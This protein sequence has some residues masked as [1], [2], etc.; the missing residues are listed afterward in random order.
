[1]VVWTTVVSNGCGE[2]RSDSVNILNAQSIVFIDKLD[3]R[4]E[5]KAMYSPK[6]LY[7][8]NWRENCH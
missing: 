5:R 1:M 8:S 3:L 4:S 7:Q 6:I 2:K